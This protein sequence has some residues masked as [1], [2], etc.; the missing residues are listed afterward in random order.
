MA[1]PPA[2]GGSSADPAAGS[3]SSSA[4][5]AAGAG[6]PV[7]TTGAGRLWAIVYVSKAAKAVTADDLQ[8][9]LDGARRRNLAEGITGVLLYADGYFM[10]YLEGEEAGLYRVYSIIKMHP[11]HYGLITLVRE[12]IPARVFSEWAMA[13]HRVGTGADAA[14]SADYALLA[15]RLGAAVAKQSEARRLLQH[16]WTDGQGAVGPALQRH[17]QTRGQAGWPPYPASDSGGRDD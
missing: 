4:D 15:S 16:F 14:L 5:P 3:G 17:S 10:Q 6:P 12:P 2:S 8:Q 11:L 1:E 7:Q 13:C 9:L